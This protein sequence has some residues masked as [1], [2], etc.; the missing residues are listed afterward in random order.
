MVLKLFGCCVFS[1]QWNDTEAVS[2]VIS[3]LLKHTRWNEQRS[4]DCPFLPETD[5]PI[6]RPPRYLRG[7]GVVRKVRGESPACSAKL[8]SSICGEEHKSEAIPQSNYPRWQEKAREE[9]DRENRVTKRRCFIYSLCYLTLCCLKHFSTNM[10][11][12]TAPLMQRNY[13][14]HN[15]NTGFEGWFVCS[16]NYEF[17]TSHREL[18]NCCGCSWC[19]C[20]IH[21]TFL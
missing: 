15:N 12:S 19:S 14:Y 21:T 8:I 5:G 16:K 20:Q 3:L 4:S 7:R 6:V 18:F 11:Y 10:M 13:L 17:I 2:S 1:Y 9:R